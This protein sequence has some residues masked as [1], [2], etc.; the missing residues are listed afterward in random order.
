M[1]KWISHKFET[2][3]LI[4]ASK[5]RKCYFSKISLHQI[6]KFAS[7]IQI[8]VIK[9]HPIAGSNLGTLLPKTDED[10]MKYFKLPENILSYIT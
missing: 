10:L 1:S 3:K 8:C 6:Q 9:V 7:N 5:G 4:V 2:K